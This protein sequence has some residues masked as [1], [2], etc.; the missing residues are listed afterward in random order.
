MFTDNPAFFTPAM[1]NMTPG[2][3]AELRSQFM[4]GMPTTWLRDNVVGLSQPIAT[5][6]RMMAR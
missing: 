4:R 2:R 3:L 1:V 6:V 5:P